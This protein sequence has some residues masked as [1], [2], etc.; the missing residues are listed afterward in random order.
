[1][2]AKPLLTG[3]AP[4]L[5]RVLSRPDTPAGVQR[6]QKSA[7]PQ[8]FISISKC[9]RQIATGITRRLREGDAPQ[10]K[11]ARRDGRRL[12]RGTFSSACRVRCLRPTDAAS[13]T[14][15]AV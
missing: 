3:D 11:D 15:R 1:M 4:F 2:R 8:Q 9:S 12:F 14:L 10:A 7:P 13:K 6:F 5:E